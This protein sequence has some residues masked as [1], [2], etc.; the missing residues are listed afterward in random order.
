[1]QQEQYTT[2]IINALELSIVGGDTQSLTKANE[3]IQ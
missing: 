2:R 1:M 3:H